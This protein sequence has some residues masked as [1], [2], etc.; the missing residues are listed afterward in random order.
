MV[1]I[2]DG[3]ADSNATEVPPS[4]RDYWA[5]A[6]VGV[7]AAFLLCGYE[8]VR[9]PSTTL[10]MDAYGPNSLPAAMAVTPL[11]IIAALYLYG[12]LLTWLGPRRALLTTTVG[13]AL[14]LAAAYL[15]VFAQWR[16]AAALL[17]VVRE[18]YVVLLVEQYWSFINSTLATRSARKLNGPICGI[19]SAG[20]IIG[21]RTVA[22][23]AER[24]GTEGLV[25]LAAVATLPAAGLM[26]LAYRRCGEP[27]DR[28]AE[29]RSDTLGLGLFSRNRVL[30]VL[31][32]VILLTQAVSTLLDLNFNGTVQATI[33]APDPQA[34]RDSRTAFL[35]TFWSRV[36]IA[37]AFMQ[38]LATPL[39]LR[40][41]PLGL[42]HLAIPL[43][44]VS[45]CVY[46]LLTE[47]LFAAG[48]AFMLFKAL[49]Y[50]TFRA[51]K[52]ILYI[53]LSFDARYRAKEV[54]DVFGY[55]FGKGGVSLAVMGAQA[56]GSPVVKAGLA[57]GALAAALAWAVLA[58]PLTHAY[59]ASS[60]TAS[61]RKRYPPRLAT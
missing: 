7:S 57:V 44:H 55:R 21:G 28:P 27:Q 30:V 60:K 16:P 12:R 17:F 36:N 1:Q 46:L 4:A 56:A 43:A 18:A 34:A 39:L 49:D 32:L 59:A 41:L 54:I 53:P 29:R 61:A 19:A 13:S 48:L 9:S 45:A 52:E 50:S 25:L 23:L 11:A 35:G 5:A 26:N 20:S 33:T 15:G 42:I 14:L 38:F 22:L 10:F 40:W 37:S 24:V 58:I 47:S 6:L 31:L 51:A 8:L 2:T 3:H